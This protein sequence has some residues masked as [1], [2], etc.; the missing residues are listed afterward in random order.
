MSV[1]PDVS[2]NASVFD[3]PLYFVSAGGVASVMAQDNIVF[4]VRTDGIVVDNVVLKG[5]KDES[6][7]KDG[8]FELSYLN[9]TGTTLEIMAD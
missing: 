2:A 4:L 8:K 1:T 5:C 9:Y 7:Y 3:G 6:L